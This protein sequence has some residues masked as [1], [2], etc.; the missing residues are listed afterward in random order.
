MTNLI[1][2]GLG[3][4]LGFLSIMVLV[5]WRRQR[6]HSEALARFS[7]SM[8]DHKMHHKLEHEEIG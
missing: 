1:W 5:I 8:F 3:F 4:W 6:Q 7:I 2:C